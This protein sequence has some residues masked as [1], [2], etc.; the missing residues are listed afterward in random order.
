MIRPKQQ[1]FPVHMYALQQDAG[2][3]LVHWK[4]FILEWQ[5]PTCFCVLVHRNIEDNVQP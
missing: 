4:I 5:A 1:A 2:Q 3:L